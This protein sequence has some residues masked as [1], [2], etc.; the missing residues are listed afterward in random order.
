MNLAGVPTMMQAVIRAK[1]ESDASVE[2]LRSIAMAGS[3]ISP[4]MLKD[5][6]SGLGVNRISTSFGMSEA[7]LITGVPFG[8]LPYK[9]RGDV[10]T[11]GKYSPGVRVRVCALN[12][13]KVF[14]RGVAGELHIGGATIIDQYIGMEDPGDTFYKEKGVRWLRTGDQAV[15]EST[16]EIFVQGRYKDVIIRGGENISPASIERLIDSLLEVVASQVVGARDD[17][18]VEVPFAVAKLVNGASINN[19]KIHDLIVEKLGTLYVPSETVSLQDLG[20]DY[21]RTDSRKV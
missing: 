6:A 4:R 12:S 8:E 11:A 17:V 5:I 16:G 18:A 21:P 1:K 20:I 9:F 15:M 13:R 2:S 14:E 7:S 10:V 19:D 3:M